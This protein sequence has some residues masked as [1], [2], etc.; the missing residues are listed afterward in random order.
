MFYEW[1]L[2]LLG[3]REG[4]HMPNNSE[5]SDELRKRIEDLNNQ[6]TQTTDTAKRGEIESQ[7]ADAKQQL[8]ARTTTIRSRGSRSP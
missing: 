5:K 3:S 8:N 2:G 6:L 7:I 1:M 4:S